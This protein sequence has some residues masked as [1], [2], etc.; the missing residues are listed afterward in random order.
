M[1]LAGIIN[2]KDVFEKDVFGWRLVSFSH[3]SLHSSMFSQFLCF[4]N[5]AFA[6]LK[7]V[8]TMYK[9]GNASKK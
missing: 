8:S 6:W 3:I 1:E 4:V 9:L 5:T 2:E 7:P